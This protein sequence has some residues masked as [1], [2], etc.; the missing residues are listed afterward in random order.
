MSQSLVHLEYV[1]IIAMVFTGVTKCSVSNT[2]TAKKI[3]S[4]NVRN[5]M[6]V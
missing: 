1:I 4:A 6:V 5:F 2:L 3:K